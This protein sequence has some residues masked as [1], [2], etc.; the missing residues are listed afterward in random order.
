MPLYEYECQECG[1]RIEVLQRFGEEPKATCDHCG[2][3]LR[4]LLSAPM[5]Q[6]KGSGWYVT[7]YAG[8]KSAASRSEGTS[9][10][11]AGGKSSSSPDEASGGSSGSS[12][13]S[14]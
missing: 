14:D 9:E 12:S 10:S 4:K 2:G 13:P 5:V 8:K 3:P 1:R 11:S 6:F 7:D